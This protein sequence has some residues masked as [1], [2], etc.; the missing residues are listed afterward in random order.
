RTYSGGMRRR[1]DLA[2]SLVRNPMVVFLDE[3]T[4]GLDPRSRLE[5]WSD[6]RALAEDGVTVL[7]TTQY[8]DEADSL[9]DRVGVL[10]HG[11]LVAEGT[12][13]ELKALIG[14]DVVTVHGTDGELVR[15]L[16]T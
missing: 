7:L 4:T 16:P 2:L 10:D 3:P 8:L 14:G 15:E 12:P 9:A 6:I 13:G 1:L 5:L 11:S